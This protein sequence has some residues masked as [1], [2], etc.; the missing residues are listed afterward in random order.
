MSMLSGPVPPDRCFAIRAA[1]ASLLSSG[2]DAGTAGYGS[3]AITPSAPASGICISRCLS[4][5]TST[6]GL[7]DL[8]SVLSG[9]RSPPPPR[10]VAIF[11]ASCTL[12]LTTLEL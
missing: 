10:L 3:N 12:P 1:A 5:R 2:S 7:P 4:R 6:T 11:T 9:L 8:A